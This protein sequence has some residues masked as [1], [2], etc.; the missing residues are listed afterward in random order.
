MAMN[1]H[2][3]PEV[4][5]AMISAELPKK[6]KFAPFATVDS[7]LTGQPGN[8]ITLPRFT[9]DPVAMGAKTLAEYE[10]MVA[11]ELATAKVD[12]TVKKAGKA[13]KLSDEEILSGYGDPVGQAGKQVLMAIADFIDNE[14]VAEFEKATLVHGTATDELDNILLASALKF[15]GENDE[16]KILFVNPASYVNFL[17]LDKFI[18]ASVYGGNVLYSGEIGQIL[19]MRVV[20]SAKVPAGKSWIAIPGA[21]TIFMK[22]NVMVEVDRDKL[23]ATN[24]IMAN[25][26]YIVALTDDT[27]V[28]ELTHKSY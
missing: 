6:I 15:F 14:V 23:S 8:T 19:G 11:T 10:A 1:N 4:L 27:K 20:K 9:Y 16:Q 21:V 18:D 28:V 17:K 22:R 24:Y 25:E 7:T 5:A 13:V 2:I 12:Y 3:N 26:H